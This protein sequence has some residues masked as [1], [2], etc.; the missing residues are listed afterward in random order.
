MFEAIVNSI[1]SIQD[2][3]RSDGYI[4]VNIVRD[5][6]QAVFDGMDD[7]RP[8][9]DFSVC[10]NGIG[11]NDDNLR[12]FQTF[13]STYK[14]PKGGKGVGRLL[15]LK[16]FDFAD[17]HSSY[18]IDGRIHTRRFSFSEKE[19][20]VKIYEEKQA[21][22]GTQ[23][24]TKVSL[25]N[26]RKEYRDASPKSQEIIAESILE[27]CLQFFLI[28]GCPTIRV[29][30]SASTQ[31]IELNELFRSK[32]T[33]RRST[34]SARINGSEYKIEHLLIRAVSTSEHKLNLCAHERVV[35]SRRMGGD[36]PNLGSRIE[37]ENAKCV[38]C[39]YVS[40]QYLDSVVNTERTGFNFPD[41]DE[42][43]GLGVSEDT[44]L[45]ELQTSIESELES[46]LRENREVIEKRVSLVIT[47]EMPEA[48]LLLRQ[49]PEISKTLRP[50]ADNKTI[51]RRISEAM[52]VHETKIRDNAEAALEMMRK[53]HVD[54]VK[55]R[56]ISE[57]TLSEI[58][59]TSRSKLAG[60]VAFRKAVL[61]LYEGRI[62]LQSNGKFSREDAVHEI[63]FP[64]RR[65]SDQIEFDEHN[66]W[67]I[68]DKLA[69]HQLLASDVP[70]EDLQV[71][72]M[73]GKRRCDLL[74]INKPAA[75]SNSTDGVSSIVIIELK[76]PERDDYDGNDNPIDQVLGYIEEIRTG[77]ARQV[78]G[79]HLNINQNSPFFVYII[80]DITSKLKQIIERRGIFV[81]TPDAE[82]YFGY[83]K[84]HNAYI[85][86]LSFQKLILDARKRNRVWFKKLNL[87]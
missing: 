27:H 36:I 41:L 82:G 50:Q 55:A 83:A 62:A 16:A 61:E 65:T 74:V 7:P 64:K 52:F 40:S 29:L 11:F 2:S 26:F 14:L 59:E 48:R 81:S 32:V 9:K 45:K 38:Y 21:V 56:E 72:K 78:D 77:K 84:G 1:H 22:Q 6:T 10:D 57:K 31:I 23:I 79:R 12:S 37:L 51:K 43:D 8:I 75:F 19:N 13:D 30:D 39:G 5:D 18:R 15:W 47:D 35:K 49:L 76:R 28:D 58:T 69:F 67:I 70:L 80:S 54:V 85:E 86:V 46:H 25:L 68:D 66:L 24:S 87:D 3:G 42:L 44:L 53:E 4:D 71:V 33:K 34:V 20:G 17:I 60:Y 63:I 73:E